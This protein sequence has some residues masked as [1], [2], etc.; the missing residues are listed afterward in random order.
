[1]YALILST[2][3]IAFVAVE[4][5]R[6]VAL[7]L[8]GT[9][10][11]NNSCE[12]CCL[13]FKAHIDTGYHLLH[14]Y[15]RTYYNEFLSNVH[16]KKMICTCEEFEFVCANNEYVTC[17]TSVHPHCNGYMVSRKLSMSEKCEEY[18]RKLICYEEKISYFCDDKAFEFWLS[19]PKSLPILDEV[20]SWKNEK[21]SLPIECTFLQTHVLNLLNE[22]TRYDELSNNTCA[23]LF[24]ETLPTTTNVNLS[25]T[26]T[27]QTETE[28]PSSAT[29]MT[30]RL[31]LLSLSGM[32]ALLA[33]IFS[34]FENVLYRK[35]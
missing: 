17:T 34:M 24:N 33:V 14:Y 28:L 3:L 32:I 31:D 10:I 30:I 4:G 35:P 6:P 9:C 26:S 21:N 12:Q 1:M 11:H 23:R 16:K 8:L 22:T 27:T 2:F 29:K 7:A 25:Q 13:N 5:G 19:S 15:C 18:C 20:V